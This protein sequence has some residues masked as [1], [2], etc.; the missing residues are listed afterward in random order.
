MTPQK[1]AF[2]TG[3]TS[4]IGK[5]TAELLAAHHFRLVICGRRKERL[6]ALAA[7]L[8]TLTEVHTLVFDV[9]D[10]EAVFDAIASLPADFQEIDVLINNAGNAHGLASFEE[11]SLQDWEAM[12]NINVNGLLYVSKALITKMVQRQ[13]G[14]II[15]IGSVAGKEAYAN[16]NAYCASKAAVDMLS[17]TMRID[18]HKHGIKV[19]AIHPGLVDTE[20]S[21]VRFKGDAQRAA[22]V[23]Q[24]MQPLVAQD[25]AEILLFVITRPP[26]VNI[27][28]LLVF[29]TAQA[30]AT[31]VK[32]G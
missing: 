25:I 10:K 18:L 7:H 17:A 24:G 6:E 2:I 13:K 3:A 32:R 31:T 21:L 4:G 15:N 12:M 30:N 11:G 22:N 5:A 16:G 9:Q 23:Y 26:H 29:P 14:H 1:T 19:G 8:Q 20:F 27:A 28:D